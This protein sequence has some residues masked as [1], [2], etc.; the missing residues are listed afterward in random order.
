[1]DI[2]SV[3][4]N[5]IAFTADPARHEFT[6]IVKGIEWRMTAAPYIEFSDGRR[7]DFPAP[8]A[9]AGVCSGTCDAIKAE[10]RGFEGSGITAEAVI[11][12]DR[13]TGDITF[14]INIT[15]DEP[16]EINVVSYPGPFC[17]GAQPGHGYTV[18][19]RMH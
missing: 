4:H 10:Y 16:G 19:P 12:M 13:G 3:E 11:K 18:L 2:L 8:F 1:M 5:G 7:A 9:V 17:Y 6:V 14:Y 15:G